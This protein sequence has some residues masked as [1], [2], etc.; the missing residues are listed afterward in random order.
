MN[1]CPLAEA[2]ESALVWNRTT[3]KARKDHKC[4]ECGDTIHKQQSYDYTSMLYD[5]QWTT[6]RTC[7]LCAEIGDH[8][9]CGN[10]RIVGELWSDLKDNFFPSMKAGGP[11]MEGLSPDA[12]SRL[13]DLRT[14]W[15]LERA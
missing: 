11:C 1:C 10:G 9:A 8:F 3:R 12:K 5:G 4:V 14:A 2:D 15:L 7:L 13:F 6:W